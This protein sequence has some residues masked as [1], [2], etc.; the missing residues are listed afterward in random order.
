[1]MAAAPLAAGATPG[2]THTTTTTTT[3]MVAHSITTYTEHYAAL[4][5]DLQ[6]RYYLLLTPYNPE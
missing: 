1:M 6:G 4:P 5:D 2:T 3:T